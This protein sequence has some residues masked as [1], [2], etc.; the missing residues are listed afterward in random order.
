MII[1]KNILLT[2]LTALSTT[3][4]IAQ[5]TSYTDTLVVTVNET[6]TYVQE[7]T[8][9]V[10][11]NN[12]KYTLSLNDFILVDGED[13]MPVGNIVVTDITMNENDGINEFETT[14][15]ITI[16]D[17]S[18]T[19]ENWKGSI[20]G[21]LPLTIKGEMTNEKLYFTLD[22]DLTNELGEVINIVFGKDIEIEEEKVI[23]YTDQLTTM[24]GQETIP[25]REE[26]IIIEKI[27]STYTL[28]LNKFTLIDNE[29]VT[30]VG[31]IAITDIVMTKNDNVKEFETEQYIN[32]TAG[33]NRE[34]WI[35]PILDTVLVKV[36]GKIENDKLSCT[37]DF[38]L[39]G[40]QIKILFGKVAENNDTQEEDYTRSYTDQLVI[41]IGENVTEPQE[42]TIIVENKNGVHTLALRNFAL[43]GLPVGD[44]V[45]TDITVTDNNG[46]KE[47]ETTQNI[48][49]TASEGVE[50]CI[51]PGLGELPVSLTGKMT[52]ERLYCTIVLNLEGLGTI[53]VVFGEDIE[54][55]YIEEEATR[56]YTDQLVI[57]IGENVTEPQETTIIVES[58][59][60][61]YTL[62]LRN[63]ALDGLPVGD[64]V[65]TD[66]TVTDNNGIK[67]FETTQ[68]IAI[69]ASE[70][71]E[72]CIG[73][74]LGELPVSLTGKM[75]NERLYCTIVLNLEGLGTINVV[76]GED[77]ES[78]IENITSN[79]ITT[80][81]DI[82]GRS[83]KAISTPGIYII[84][85][86]K[87]LVK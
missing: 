70:G 40:M 8:I 86:K 18:N 39:A 60:G 38:E 81:F 84:N 29:E 19:E 17:G 44:I 66:I 79:D 83:V 74:G 28:Y 48:A 14:Q 5:A 27:D 6:D 68:N 80:I 65:V 59:N 26:T 16:T 58:N 1:M 63:F 12:E 76:F 47:F 36:C 42:T 56:S 33:D 30:Y 7:V 75:T 13:R 73:P 15:N 25:A 64:I 20:L 35:G 50:G 31:N 52:K 57:A 87:V 78:G 77:I 45:V 22:L 71:V 37:I 82:N 21:E 49:I 43:D 62:A 2:I 11:N 3:T 53:N 51:G 34:T 41:A 67:E 9:N 55:G 4:A 72:G 46:I 23:E 85:G 61:V 10:E 32:I 54:H 69:T 24:V